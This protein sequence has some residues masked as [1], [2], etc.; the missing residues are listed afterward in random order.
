MCIDCKSWSS[1]DSYHQLHDKVE[2]GGGGL[3]MVVIST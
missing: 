1:V 3:L 2:V